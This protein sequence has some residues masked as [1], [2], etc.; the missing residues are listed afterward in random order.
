MIS[1]F[2]IYFFGLNL[3]SKVK[4]VMFLNGLEG[5]VGCGSWLVVFGECSIEVI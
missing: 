5:E 3:Y 1:C 2:E 4:Y